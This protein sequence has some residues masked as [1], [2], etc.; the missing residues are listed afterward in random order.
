MKRSV[1]SDTV[2]YI[3]D[4][5]YGFKSL[6]H[7]FSAAL[8]Y[9]AGFGELRKEVTEQYPDPISSKT[10][11]D[12]PS[13]SRGI[14]Y[15]DIE[16]CT[17]C[18]ECEKSCPSR[19]IRIQTEPGPDQAQLWVTDFDLDLSKCTLC[20]ICVEECVPRSLVHTK[21]YSG[22]MYDLTELVKSFGKGSISP[23]ERA[24]WEI[25]RNMS[26]NDGAFL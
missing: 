19:A 17:G 10:P 1:Y 20:G 16:R 18:R 21:K 3:A 26:E 4:V 15:N 7:A 11:D 22:S 9:L 5:Y 13:R 23:E 2:K 14:L 8:P 6:F 25:T 24:K 12:L